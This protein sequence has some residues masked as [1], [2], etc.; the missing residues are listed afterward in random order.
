M[1]GPRIR[2]TKWVWQ[3]VFGSEDDIIAAENGMGQDLA[4]EVLHQVRLCSDEGLTTA[5][6]DLGSHLVRWLVNQRRRFRFY[7]VEMPS[8]N[9]FALPGGHVF[10]TRSILELCQG[11][12]DQ[13]AFVLAHEM[14]HVVRGHAMNRMMTHSA[15]N[16]A[17][18]LA[19]TRSAIGAWAKQVG[20]SAI[21]SAY[22]QDQE[23]EADH[24][25][26]LLIK[27]AGHD[28][29]AAEHL[30]LA[31]AGATSGPGPGGL[32]SYFSSHPPLQERITA[33]RRILKQGG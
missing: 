20:V 17:A 12:Q 11:R 25:A 2:K 1:A 8:P 21:Q 19:A 18:G 24:M 22:S 4:A 30:I 5:V 10:V 14:A 31:L 9:A 23:F 32:E 29:H 3:S 6:C 27:A 16:L 15:I 13:M 7:V 28:G 33:I 26:V